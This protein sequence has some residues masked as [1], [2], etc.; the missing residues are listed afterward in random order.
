MFVHARVLPKES[1][2]WQDVR[3][4][5]VYTFQRGKDAKMRAFANREDA[6]TWV[7]MNRP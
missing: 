4:A 6:L 1:S 2:T 5:D 3:L 7:R